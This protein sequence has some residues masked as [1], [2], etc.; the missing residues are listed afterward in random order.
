MKFLEVIGHKEVKSKLIRMV[1]GGKTPHAIMLLGPE[2]NGNLA[3]ALALT[4]FVQCENQSENDSCG[5]CPSCLRN[6]KFI[7]PDVHFSFPVYKPEKKNSP[8]V[9]ADY[10][11]NWRSALAQN[12]YMSYNDW[13]QYIE[14]ENKQGKITADECREII[15]HL[16]LKTYENGYKIHI[17]W[18]AEC[19]GNEGNILLKSL[20]EP[21]PKTVFIL[22][23]ESSEH[24]LTTIL[25]RVQIIKVNA[26]DDE[27][28][29]EALLK[30]FEMDENT[31][32][33]IARISDGNLNT[34]ISIADGA[35]NANDAT[36][37]QWL[38]CCFNLKQK[39]SADNTKNLNEWIDEFSKTGRENQKIF[40][41]YALFFLR[42]CS[43][44][45]ILGQSG[46]L[47]GDELQFASKLSA[48]LSAEQFETLS[49]I[50]S[51]MSYY[52]ERN[53]NPKILFMSNSFKIA[54]VFKNEEVPED[55]ISLS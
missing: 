5:T 38:L 45:S 32:K 44:V 20:E 16:S 29:K 13:M 50:F 36:L 43:Q 33:R 47:E 19:L 54:S 39:P 22:I 41:K 55:G 42:E 11:T 48:R 24:M 34:A 37:R 7:H 27:D 31:A 52:I 10:M 3:V 6:Q 2:G 51:R 35:E 8:P 12:A 23:A 18:L 14:A 21:P 30:K 46:K 1:R 4:Q 25:S 28:L 15:H 17:I 53:C 9:S 26:I 40:L 49:K